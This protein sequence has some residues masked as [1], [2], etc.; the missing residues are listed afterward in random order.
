MIISFCQFGLYP[1]STSFVISVEKI[2]PWPS[3]SSRISC[4]ATIRASNYPLNHTLISKPRLSTDLVGYVFCCKCFKPYEENI[5]WTS[6]CVY[7]AFPNQCH[8]ER[9]EQCKVD[10]EIHDQGQ[11]LL[12]PK[13]PSIQP[14]KVGSHRCLLVI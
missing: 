5:L 8:E 13:P 10:H 2:G 11:P 6:S 3:S 9:F 1:G 7:L 12:Q 14:M 4:K